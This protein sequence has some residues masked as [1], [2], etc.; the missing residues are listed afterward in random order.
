MVRPNRKHLTGDMPY[1]QGRE[2]KQHHV[3][4]HTFD[5]ISQPADR[6]RR[7]FK[8]PAA[9]TQPKKVAG[10]PIRFPAPTVPA[11]SGYSL[12]QTAKMRAA[13]VPSST[14]STKAEQQPV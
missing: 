4:L 10:F 3:W 12:P 2:T 6:P 9:S 14:P 13:A 1:R 8:R 5:P 7:S 11:T